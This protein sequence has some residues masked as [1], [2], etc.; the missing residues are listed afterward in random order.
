MNE[1]GVERVAPT[2]CSDHQ[3]VKDKRAKKGGR[4]KG[5]RGGKGEKVE[6]KKEGEERKK[7]V[8]ETKT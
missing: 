1:E 7:T 2:T 4:R 5:E 6:G 8:E 3:Q